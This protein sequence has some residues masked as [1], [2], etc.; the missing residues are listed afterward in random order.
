MIYTTQ[1]RRL[2]IDPAQPDASILARAAAVLQQGGLVAFP[3]ETVYGL[4]ANAL[5]GV[6]VNRI[7]AAKE[8]PAND[9]VIVHIYDDRQLP[10]V[11]NDV[12]SVVWRLRDVFWPGALTLVLR[13]SSFIPPNV[14]SGL[15]TVAVRMPAGTIARELLRAAELPIAAPSANTFSRPSA[16]TAD[17]V[18][19]DLDGHVD[20]VLDGGATMMG[21][22]STVL[23]LTGDI[24]TVLRP[25][26]V[27]LE[28]LREV[29]PTVQVRERMNA[30]D[31]PATEASPGLLVK[32]YSPR[33]QFLLYDGTPEAA[34]AAMVDEAKR[35][36]A[37]GKRIGVLIVNEDRPLF[38]GLALFIEMLGSSD[39][40][41]QVG[42]RLFAGLRA[43]DAHRVEV[44]LA[45]TLSAEGIGAAI[46]DRMLRA[47]EG[48]RIAT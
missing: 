32:H 6:A 14:S 27:T 35:L 36:V 25:G 29:L 15:R 34:R 41:P 3:T 31:A 20:M 42:T 47:A 26:G 22:E 43:L 40:L 21:L 24:P 16:T 28:A 38:D 37:Q 18:M 1:T 10:L 11:A 39:D 45:R 12:P 19:E 33:A 23:D 17:H 8:R 13:R 2:F 4:G 46:A 30:A 5:D 44:I 9:P 7:F 48:K